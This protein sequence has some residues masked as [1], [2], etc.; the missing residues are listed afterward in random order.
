MQWNEGSHVYCRGLECRVICPTPTQRLR[1]GSGPPLTAIPCLPHLPSTF[2]SP[3]PPHLLDPVVPPRSSPTMQRRAASPLPADGAAG[4]SR[5]RVSTWGWAAPPPLGLARPLSPCRKRQ[6]WAAVTS[7]L[8]ATT[9]PVAQP[10]LC[11]WVRRPPLP[12]RWR[13]GRSGLL[14][15]SSPP[16]G[17]VSVR[18]SILPPP[19]D[20]P[21]LSMALR[22]H[23]R[24]VARLRRALLGR[25]GLLENLPP[26]RLSRSKVQRL[27]SSGTWDCVILA[28]VAM[29]SVLFFVGTLPISAE[30]RGRLRMTELIMN[31][32]MLGE[33]LARWWAKGWHL[34]YLRSPYTMVDIL[35]VVPLVNRVVRWV[36]GGAIAAG[37]WVVGL[38]T[39]AGVGAATAGTGGGPTTVAAASAVAAAAATGAASTAGVA[40]AVTTAT[41]AGSLS[42][43]RILRLTRVLRISRVLSGRKS[44][45]LAR[46]PDAQLRLLRILFSLFS[47]V[48]LFSGLIYN[49]ERVA[50]PA[51]STF[52]HS[53]YFCVGVMAV[54]Y[55]DAAPVTPLGKLVTATMIV[56]GVVAIPWQVASLLK[57]V[58]V[59]QSK[60]ETVCG[61]CG[62]RFHDPDAVYCKM[63][64]T[65]I[66][67]VYDGL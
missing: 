49:A 46:L 7:A 2:P 48:W 5:R 23:S 33:L 60:R 9:T 64:G 13:R 54:G 24:P 19:R 4:G 22:R 20:V 17:G 40:A 42:F 44:G 28:E 18:H 39:G 41:P 12:D 56:T 63:C 53:L 57:S 43:V 52:A 29:L 35:S 27:L 6:G 62:L 26:Y 3:L 14:S 8:L 66:F 65:P 59:A 30:L 55:A 1:F 50:Q 61:R 16:P 34:E 36:L 10:R 11:S 15:G 45:L 38:A 37:A 31:V 32:G 51:F 67:Q 25:C 47:I 58:V 21:P